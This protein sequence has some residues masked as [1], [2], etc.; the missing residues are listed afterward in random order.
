MA[1]S[2][3]IVSDS[4][5]K[6]R[7]ASETNDKVTDDDHENGVEGDEDDEEYEIEEI[8]KHRRNMFEDGRIGYFCRWKGYG[9]DQN[10]WVDE[11]DAGNAT[12]LIDAYWAKQNAKKKPRKSTDAKTRQS[13]AAES[14][15]PAPAP[16]KRGRKS[17]AKSEDVE[18]EEEEQTSK[19]QRTKTAS[20]TKTQSTEP[21]DVVMEELED[22][23]SGPE[24]MK[25]HF[26]NRKSWEDIVDTIDT[27]ERSP[28][29]GS[30]LV[31]FR[32]NAKNGG[33][34]VRLESPICREKFP[35]ALITFYE[36]NLKWKETEVD[37][38]PLS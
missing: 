29:D 32:L 18:P 19:R 34:R 36:S 5:E 23:I 1:R 7:D 37:D 8:L 24:Y 11:K 33:T 28:T 3:S 22:Q 26:P 17:A 13:T 6:A 38:M 12:E 21:E 20:R 30:L 2:A 27:V 16:K 14:P 9:P 35:Q 10:S 31:Y 15:D 4:D 25:K